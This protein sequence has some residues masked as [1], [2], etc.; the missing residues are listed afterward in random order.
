MGLKQ[1]WLGWSTTTRAS[2]SAH[3]Q[4][5]KCS[6]SGRHSSSPL[7]TTWHL[8]TELK[9][10]A[11]QSIKLPA[12]GGDHNQVLLQA[13]TKWIFWSG[14]TTQDRLNEQNKEVDARYILWG[15]VLP[16]FISLNICSPSSGMSSKFSFLLIWVQLYMTQF[17]KLV[18]VF[19]CFVCV[20]VNIFGCC[21]FCFPWADISSKW[22]EGLHQY[23]VSMWNC[24][25]H[26][27]NDV[28]RCHAVTLESGVTNKQEI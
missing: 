5:K 19:V 26:L 17:N 23:G 1:E 20:V 2:Q 8:L 13:E 15:F 7:T 28:S 14:S 22:R 24:L 9:F 16:P 11:T 25:H 18:L 3:T 27:F 6:L 10:W 12:R 4:K 21:V